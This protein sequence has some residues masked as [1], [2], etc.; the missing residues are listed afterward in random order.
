[1][2][3]IPMRTC[4]GC[5]EK[6]P[7]KELI[8]VVK[9]SEGEIFVDFSGRANGRGAYVCHDCACLEKA[10]K[11]KRLSRAFEM[12]IDNEIYDKLKNEI[13]KDN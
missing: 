4:I 13:E 6:K 5:N 2:K 7:K 3:K 12:E 1:M 9:P 8:R 11:T 10:I